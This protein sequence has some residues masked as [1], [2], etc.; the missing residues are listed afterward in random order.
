MVEVVPGR[1]TDA[2][3]FTYQEYT[4]LSKIIDKKQVLILFG[5]Q[6]QKAIENFIKFHKINMTESEMKDYIEYEMIGRLTDEEAKKYI[7]EILG[8]KNIKQIAQYDIEKR[9]KTLKKLKNIHG[10]S[11]LQI[12]R[13]TGLSK[14]MVEVAMK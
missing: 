5:M 6:E 9:K 4:S 8:I 3:Y 2:N 14:R 1:L 7:E 12:A 10:I 13:I 11:N